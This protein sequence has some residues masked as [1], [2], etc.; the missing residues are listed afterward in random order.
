MGSWTGKGITKQKKIL[1]QLPF[2]PNFLHFHHFRPLFPISPPFSLRHKPI[3]DPRPLIYLLKMSLMGFS[4][5]SKFFHKTKKNP[6]APT[7]F[8]RF[9]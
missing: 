6:Q 1:S 7:I 5:L 3:S 8:P 9:R 4:Q 2:P